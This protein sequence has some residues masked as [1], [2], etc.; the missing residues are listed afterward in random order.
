MVL[1]RLKMIL[2]NKFNLFLLG[3][4]LRSRSRS[5]SSV[6]VRRNRTNDELLPVVVGW[7][8]LGDVSRMIALHRQ[9]TGAVDFSVEVRRGF[10]SVGS[11]VRGFF[12]RFRYG[13]LVR[14]EVLVD[15]FVVDR[16]GYS[17]M[18]EDNRFKVVYVFIVKTGVP[19]VRS[20]ANVEVIL[21]A[22]NFSLPSVTDLWFGA[23]WLE[24]EA[25][26][27]SGVRFTG[28]P[29][30]RRLL[31]DYGFRGFPMRKEFPPFGFKQ[32]RYDERAG[33][34]V[35]ERL[36]LAQQERDAHLINPWHLSWINLGCS[37]KPEF[38]RGWDLYAF[39][40]SCRIKKKLNENEN[41]LVG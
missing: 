9:Q 29:D 31:T 36:E 37:E 35:Y 34:V 2:F 17:G 39:A 20:Y 10:D 7:L 14:G 32:V 16:L 40:F 19:F 30:L 6:V 28:H 24:R 33:S 15:L 11:M 27:M 38:C 13:T 4:K 41:G 1:N 5:I 21:G 12:K 25:W 23:E 22:K 3:E 8:G 18:S 26:D